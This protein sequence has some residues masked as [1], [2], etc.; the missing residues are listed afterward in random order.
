[1]A[2]R[3]KTIFISSV[4]K[5]LAPERRAVKDFVRNDAL[6]RR[7]FEVF[8]FEDLSAVG[9][10]ADEVYLEE[11]GRCD[12]YVGLFANEY[13]CEDADD[14]SPTEREF[15]QAT[16]KGKPRLVFV[17]GADDK[18]RHPK[19]LKLIRKTGLQLI[20]RRFTDIPDLTAALYAAL[21]EH[22]ERSGDLRTLPFDAS[23]CPRATMN[24]LP[25]EK[26]KWFLGLAKRE[27][28]YPLPA[29]TSREKALAHLNLL[30][31]G[32]AFFQLQRSSASIF[33]AR[34]FASRSLPTRFSRARPLNWWIRL[35]IS[36]CPKSTGAL[37]PANTAFR[38]LRHTNCPKRL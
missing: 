28:N 27:R 30:D 31:D 21:V 14:L 36:F 13:G 19:M 29:R 38:P 6:L 2:R 16:S 8:L 4:Q 17:K 18:A 25:Q 1:M 24:D 35:W 15:D 26:I 32:S 5:E 22:L 3:R 33:T 20:R 10:R 11:V 9:R 23:A 34:K 37:E 7:F 12:V